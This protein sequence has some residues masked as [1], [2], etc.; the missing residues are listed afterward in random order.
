MA[1]TG[2][3]A[4]ILQ[5][6]V[7]LTTIPGKSNAGILLNYFSFFTILTNILVALSLTLGLLVPTTRIGKFFNKPGVES[8]IAV[9]IVIVG[10][11]YY[12]L[13][14][15]LWNPQGLQLIADILLHKLIPILYFLYWILFV[16]KV[17]L[18]WGAAFRWLC[19]P[20]LYFCYVLIRGAIDGF[21]PYPFGDVGQ[22]GYPRALFNACLVLTGFYLM[23]LIVV[24]INKMM[25]R[26]NKNG[27]E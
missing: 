25:F 5:L 3:F 24:F 2:W 15:K 26:R 23:G 9:Y 22:L 27:V 16:P 17:N 1:L 18:S 4:L 8:A 11:V 20:F 12:F 7:N 19:Y 21:Y 6:Y 10:I 14:M 13:L